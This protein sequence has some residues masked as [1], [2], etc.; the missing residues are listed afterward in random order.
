[1]VLAFAGMVGALNW[2]RGEA[3]RDHLHHSE[4]MDRIEDM[5][6]GVAAAVPVAK[7]L[8]SHMDS[9]NL[10]ILDLVYGAGNK[11]ENATL[12][13][14]QE[15]QPLDAAKIVEALTCSD[16][17][18]TRARLVGILTRQT[19]Q[20]FGDNAV[21]WESW[22]AQQKIIPS[23]A[24]AA[25]YL[26]FKGLLYHRIDPRLVHSFAINKV[27]SVPPQQIYWAGLQYDAAP[28]RRPQLIDA[29]QASY[30][31]PEDQVFGIAAAS[32][33]AIALP[34]RIL[35]WH[36]IVETVLGS[37]PITAVY[38]EAKGVVY[39]YEMTSEITSKTGCCK[40]ATSSFLYQGEHL[41]SDANSHS[42]WS[43][44]SGKPIVYE[45]VGAPEKNDFGLRK[46]AV[47]ATSWSAWLRE[48]PKTKVLAID[49]GFDRDYK[50]IEK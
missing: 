8:N 24:Q 19:G 27:S 38:D 11:Q 50:S 4:A 33:A 14:E 41:I 10:A 16:T 34:R 45:Q 13:L 7:W 22:I 1:M 21:A 26:N 6:L 2:R 48:H 47:F 15:W 23:K 9:H 17:A 39:A 37:V 5:R 12:L 18:A 42:L 29:G 28:L 3:E 32:G 40:A 25:S 35:V 36:N 49:T 43:V 30:L 44:R 20:K 46:L 31:K